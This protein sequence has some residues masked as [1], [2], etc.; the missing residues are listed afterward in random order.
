MIFL[1]IK[2]IHIISV[3]AW[4]A[5]LFYLPRLF[6]YHAKHNNEKYLDSVFKIMESKLLGVIANPAL[7]I[8]WL[9]GISLI[10]YLEIQPW[11]IIKMIFVFLMT[12]FHLFLFFALKKFENNL[13]NYSERFYRIINEVPTLLLVIIIVLVVFQPEI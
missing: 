8:V 3:I 2:T 4:M 7:I 1:T 6:V 5:A 12:L 10:Y 11:L 9:S 13:N